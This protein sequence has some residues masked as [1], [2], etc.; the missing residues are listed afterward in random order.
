MCGVYDERTCGGVDGFITNKTELQD[1]IISI[2][3]NVRPAVV[4]MDSLIYGKTFTF[5][6]ALKSVVERF[7]Y[8]YIGL[9]FC[10]SPEKAVERVLGR[11]GG[12]EFDVSNLL[13]GYNCVVYSSKKMKAAGADIR[14]IDTGKYRLEEMGTILEE[15]F[16]EKGN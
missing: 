14:F 1:Y 4:I 11:N 8:K 13:S 5:G 9:A 15:A 16:S 12:K 3:K 10:P 7:G 6:M 2:L